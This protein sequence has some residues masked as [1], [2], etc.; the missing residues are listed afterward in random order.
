MK[1]MLNSATVATNSTSVLLESIASMRSI[2]F[3]SSRSRAVVNS[4]TLNGLE[5]HEHDEETEQSVRD[6]MYYYRAAIS[7]I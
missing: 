1:I 2:H 7:R 6:L 5:G 4:P 3:K